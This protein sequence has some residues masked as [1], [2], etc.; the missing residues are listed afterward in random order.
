MN[1][2]DQSSPSVK[3]IN[4]Q[5]DLGVASWLRIFESKIVLGLHLLLG[6]NAPHHAMWIAAQLHLVLTLYHPDL[7][8]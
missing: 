8:L 5:I 1:F 6:V 3:S 2:G 4:Q 7:P